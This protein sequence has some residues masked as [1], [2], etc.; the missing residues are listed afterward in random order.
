MDKAFKGSRYGKSGD[1]YINCP[2]NK[3]TYER[4]V[5]ELTNAECTGIREF[6]EAKYFEGCLPIEV[7]AER[8]PMTLSFGP[9]K[10]VGLSGEKAG[11]K[12]GKRVK[13]LT[14]S[15]SSDVRTKKIRSTIWSVFRRG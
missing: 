9:L 1:D 6:E 8:G 11:E 15:S 10:P 3:E 7:M 5:E 12:A 13:G 2:M 4:F 14:Q